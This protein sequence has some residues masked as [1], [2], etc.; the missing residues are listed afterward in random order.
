M[1]LTMKNGISERKRFQEKGVIVDARK[2]K[3]RRVFL[4]KKMQK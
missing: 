2:I 3:S 4:G 1:G